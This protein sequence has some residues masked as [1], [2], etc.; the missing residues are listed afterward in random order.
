[1]RIPSLSID[2]EINPLI[3]DQEMDV[4][5]SYWEGAVDI[6]GTKNGMSISGSGYV[7]MTGYAASM[8]GQF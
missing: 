7:E 8:E 1:L 6:S 3:A 2:L 5:Y 4:S